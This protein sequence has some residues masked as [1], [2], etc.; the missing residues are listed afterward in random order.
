MS[1]FLLLN[2]MKIIKMLEMVNFDH[3]SAIML[4][5]STRRSK[6]PVLEV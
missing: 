1:E 3:M 5:G 6:A 2:I 4:T